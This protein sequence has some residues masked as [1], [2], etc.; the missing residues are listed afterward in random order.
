MAPEE[1]QWDFPTPTAVAELR[2]LVARAEVQA[3][4]ASA[5]EIMARLEKT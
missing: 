1:T 5:R 4:A 3:A 2:E